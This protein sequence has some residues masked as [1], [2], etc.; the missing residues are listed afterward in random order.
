MCLP[1]IW[2][3]CLA[4]FLVTFGGVDRFEHKFAAAFEKPLRRFG[5]TTALQGRAARARDRHK[6]SLRLR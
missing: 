1:W 4:V 2:L 5:N 3:E 6:T